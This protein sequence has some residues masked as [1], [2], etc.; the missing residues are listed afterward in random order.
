M[1]ARTSS[2]ASRAARAPLPSSLVVR[3][4]ALAA[5]LPT[6]QAGAR[7]GTA[8][9]Q[10]GQSSAPRVL[11]LAAA[12]RAA[13][14]QQPQIRVA[15][16]QTAV[17]RATADEVRSPLLPQVVGTAQYAHEWGAFRGVGTTGSAIGAT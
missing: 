2:V 6:V 5:V 13:L 17:A 1:R 14:E 7:W 12:E 15:R 9:A 3:A 8:W 11:T 10:E 16:A 4:M